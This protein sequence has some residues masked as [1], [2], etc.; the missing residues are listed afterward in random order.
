L[1]RHICTDDHEPA[2]TIT[3]WS[4]PFRGGG[5]EI[6]E[7]LAQAAAIEEVAFVE[8]E[9]QPRARQRGR[10]QDRGQSRRR[11]APDRA[12]RREPVNQD[13]R[14]AFTWTRLF[15]AL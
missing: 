12:R 8:I 13:E 6:A 9:R 10:Q 5:A 11:V 3:N 15:P 4:P 1:P 7:D 14:V 2:C